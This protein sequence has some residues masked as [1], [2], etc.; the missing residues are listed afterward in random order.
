MFAECIDRSTI[1]CQRAANNVVA[2]RLGTVSKFAGGCPICYARLLTQRRHLSA[3]ELSRTLTQK[4]EVSGPTS[5]ICHS[6][7]KA[8]H[9][10]CGRCKITPRGTPNTGSCYSIA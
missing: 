5:P 10:L 3:E 2:R 6:A 7:T 1:L 9:V 4:P 8:S